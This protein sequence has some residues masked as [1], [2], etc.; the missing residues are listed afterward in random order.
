MFIISVLLIVSLK[1][2]FCDV[3]YGSMVQNI[4]MHSNHTKCIYF[5][6]TLRLEFIVTNIPGPE[7]LQEEDNE[8]VC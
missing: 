5:L 2:T 6:E 1:L 3:F 8:Y 4:H 7:M